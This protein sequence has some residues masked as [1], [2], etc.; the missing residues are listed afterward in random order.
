VLPHRETQ[1]NRLH[2]RRT[3]PAAGSLRERVPVRAG[4]VPTAPARQAMARATKV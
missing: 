3:G 2:L 4:S 1:R